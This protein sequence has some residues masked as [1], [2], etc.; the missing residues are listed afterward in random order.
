MNSEANA[1]SFDEKKKIYAKHN[2]RMIKEVVE[3]QDW[4]LASIERREAVIAAWA[5]VRWADV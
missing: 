2:L 4:T 1:D 3:E 5:R